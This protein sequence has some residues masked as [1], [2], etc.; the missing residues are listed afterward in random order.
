MLDGC[1]VLRLFQRTDRASALPSRFNLSVLDLVVDGA[2][3]VDAGAFVPDFLR[4]AKESLILRQALIH[5][6][7]VE[8]AV[9]RAE[10]LVAAKRG[11]F[12]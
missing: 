11:L 2:I 9:R 3:C 8:V 12:Y 10:G 1:V 7:L 6:H 5:L 4:N